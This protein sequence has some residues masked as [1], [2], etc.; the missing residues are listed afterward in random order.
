MNLKLGLKISFLILLLGFVNSYNPKHY[1]MDPRIHS[2]GNHGI[3]GKVHSLLSPIFTKLIDKVAYKGVDIRKQVIE[4]YDKNLKKLDLCCGVGFSTPLENSIGVDSSYEMIK[5]ARKLF[6]EKEFILGNAENY[7]PDYKV[8]IT[9]IFFGFHEIPQFARLNIINK[10]QK[11]TK[12]EIIIVDISPEYKPSKSM[13][14]GEPYLLE[15]KENIDYDLKKFNKEILIS[16]HVNLWSL[17]L[18]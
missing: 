12:K 14:Y 7:T 11:Y 15:Y 4:S 17:K 13:L 6:P 16:G 3:G 10:M 18:K 9:T 5:M 2:L 1:Y 8:D